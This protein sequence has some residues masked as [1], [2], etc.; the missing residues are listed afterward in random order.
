MCQRT[1]YADLAA[2][3]DSGIADWPDA[4]VLGLSQV[5]MALY[6]MALHSQENSMNKDQTSGRAKQVKGAVKEAA[7]AVVGNKSLELKG[8]VQKAQGKVQ[9]AYGDAKQEVKKST[10]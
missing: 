10:R 6:L 2:Y 9:T 7:G 4:V 5:P 1:V 3:H 8:K